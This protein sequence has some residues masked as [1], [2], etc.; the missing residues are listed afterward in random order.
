MGGE[1]ELLV[2][3]ANPAGLLSSYLHPDVKREGLATDF[4]LKDNLA[5]NRLSLRMGGAMTRM[6]YGPYGLPLASNG[7]TQPAIGQPAT[8]G[9][10]NQRYDAETGLQYLHARYYDPLLGRFLS[11]DSWDPTIPGVGTNRYA[12]AG[13]DP[14][15]MSD[16]NGHCGGGS[17]TCTQPDGSNTPFHPDSPGNTPDGPIRSGRN[18]NNTGSGLTHNNSCG[19]CN[20]NQGKNNAGS[21]NSGGQNAWSMVQ[22]ANQCFDECHGVRYVPGRPMTPPEEFWLDATSIAATIWVPGL[23]GLKAVLGTRQAI[24][25]AEQLSMNRAAGLAF[26]KAVGEQLIKKEIEVGAQITIKTESGISTR[27]DFMT[28]DPF[29]GKLNCIEC[30]A[31]QTAPLTINQ[32]AAFEEIAKSGGTI[33][34][35]GK[36]GFPGGTSLPPTIVDIIRGN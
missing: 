7:A 30:K 12:Y 10:I 14:I 3:A 28:K 5:S 22:L 16:P 21:G 13:D 4:L 6:D 20:D 24:T 33:T 8:K 15:N 32:A 19:G 34:G 31:S 36:L 17:I 26:E 18:D 25:A 9:Y 29:T 2:N 27:L 35:A 1:A 11:P 23:G